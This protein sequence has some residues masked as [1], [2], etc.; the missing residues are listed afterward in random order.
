MTGKTIPEGK[1]T[2][3]DGY[4][5]YCIGQGIIENDSFSDYNVAISRS[6][7]AKIFA[8]AVDSE[9]LQ[10]INDI[11]GIPDIA[12]DDE[13]FDCILA[14]YNAGV[15]GGSDDVGSFMPDSQIKRSELSA[16]LSRLDN[17]SLRVKNEIPYSGFPR[18]LID[19][20][21]MTGKWGLQSGWDY[22]VKYSLKNTNGYESFSISSESGEKVGL[23]RPVNVV[24]DGNAIF[25]TAITFS[26][27]NIGAYVALED[28]NNNPVVKV[29]SKNN[30][31]YIQAGTKTVETNLEVC[32]NVSETHAFVFDVDLKKKICNV[33]IDASYFANIPIDVKEGIA[34]L[35]IAH[36]GTGMGALTVNGARGVADYRVNDNFRASPVSV[37]KGLVGEWKTTGDVTVGE[38]LSERGA[39]IYS[40]KAKGNSTASKKF[41]KIGAQFCVEANVL[42]P[43]NTSSLSLYL[44]K[45]NDKAFEIVTKDGFFISGGKELRAIP[46]N[47]WTNIRIEA[48][49]HSATAF[50]R[51]NG[52]DCGTV[53]FKAEYVDGIG[54]ATQAEVW[55]DDVKVFGTYN[56]KDYPEEPKAVNEGGYDIGINVCNLW[57]N[58]TCDEGYDAIAPF[59]E[60]HPLVGLADE[61]LPELAD[62]EVKQMAEHGID[63]QHICW[64]SPQQQTK[65][66]I[67]GISM[68]QLALNDGYL[69]AKYSDYVK[70]C[71]MW[72]NA[73]GSV[74]SVQQFKDYLWPYF[75]EYYLSDSRYYTINNRPLITIWSTTKFQDSFGGASNAK[76]II[77]FMDHDIKS[78]GYD[79]IYVWTMNSSSTLENIKNVGGHAGY[80][81]NYGKSG[82][83]ADYQ[84]K[85]MEDKLKDNA[86]FYIP[87]VSVGFNDVGRHDTRSGLIT[88][89][90]HEEVC[91]YIRDVY[92]PAAFEDNP[93]KN[94]L[95][96][97]TWNEY[98]EGTYIAPNNYNGFEY[99]DNIRE[100][101]TD[102]PK[103]HVDEVPSEKVKDR[104]RNIYPD[105]YSPIRRY[106]LEE[107]PGKTV[108]GL[109]KKSKKALSWSFDNEEHVSH[110]R[111]SHG[112]NKLNVNEKSIS[113]TSTE[114]DYG[115]T[116]NKEH[117]V[118]LDA[119]NDNIIFLHVRMKSDVYSRA[120]LFFTC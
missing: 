78:L 64:Y 87:S 120:D 108:E 1:E 25:D 47:V 97:S 30:A 35:A 75:K 44:T 50:I 22:D 79:G 74:Q 5:E 111:I 28:T 12:P 59:D 118:Q 110:W 56:Y 10:K 54:F 26:G 2:W 86:T 16:I 52:K 13:N 113:G 81:Y 65:A 90:G 73:N 20:H 99:L 63:F 66:P 80:S 92:L 72:E 100:Y 43:K 21:V 106:R 96:V 76:A 19:D 70:F 18:Y 15:F 39:D 77:D 27:K 104:L 6:D 88:D 32:A 34:R 84:I 101:F 42:L 38:L 17:E 57:R 71:I 83:N 91:K 29:Y 24:K 51:I 58:G 114:V 107:D 112:I 48:D 60:L 62:I 119:E 109:L 85:F 7:S 14:L 68:P 49:L 89:E 3:Y 37:N 41:E 115:I 45:E 46:Y 103:D 9:K 116:L 53:P 102:A 93:F 33:T 11:K 117:L 67:K 82:E 105:G 31:F 55:F 36:D 40:A 98:S 95:M 61:G 94:C 23:Y 4:V 8:N 69:K